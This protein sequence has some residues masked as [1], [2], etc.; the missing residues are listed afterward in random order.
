MKK[1]YLFGF[2]IVAALLL[3]SQP[4]FALQCKTGNDASDECWTTGQTNTNDAGQLIAGTIMAYDYETPTSQSNDATRAAFYVRTATSVDRNYVVAGVLQRTYS[5]G[6]R[7]QMLVRGKGLIRAGAAVNSFDRLYVARGVAMQRGIAGKVYAGQTDGD[8][9]VASN[10]N[11][12]A[13][14]LTTTTAAA[15]TDAFITVV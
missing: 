14:A 15:T 10:D 13:F 8:A 2:L 7:V 11:H 4:A 1:S 5:S 12:I 9:G 6:D 3:V